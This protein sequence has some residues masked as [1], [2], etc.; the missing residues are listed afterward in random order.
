[1]MS[2]NAFGLHR[3]GLVAGVIIA[4]IVLWLLRRFETGWL[5]TIIV[6]IIALVAGAYGGS[7]FE[8]IMRGV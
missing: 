1:M 6:V 7:Y 5:M 4:L 2:L 8:T 3:L